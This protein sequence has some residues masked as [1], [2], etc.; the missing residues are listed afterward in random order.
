MRKIFFWLFLLV[1][2]VFVINKF[3]SQSQIISPLADSEST[4]K[5][6]KIFSKKPK[7]IKNIS[8][9][10][11]QIKNLI[12]NQKGTYSVYIYI[13]RTNQSAGVNESV[14]YTG[15]S[16]NKVPILAALYFE[17]QNGKI[18]LSE[19]VTVQ[20]SDIQDYGTGVL[21]NEG[22]GGVYSLKNLAK[23]MME[24][25]DNTAAFILDQK[26]GDNRVQ[27]LV[28][29]WGLSQTDM[30][31]NLTSNKNMADL[32]MKMYQG[33]IVNQPLT[34]EMMDF[35]NDSDFENRLPG[36]L[37]GNI[38]VYHKIGTEIGYIH[39]VGIIDLPENPYYLGVLSSDISDENQTEKTIADISKLVFDFMNK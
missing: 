12:N 22:A 38:E 18:D 24:Q 9:I 35:L 21:R 11:P 13:L 7:D 10:I 2:F 26:I 16:L 17:A 4:F 25:S 27:E 3:R 28:D 34:L 29:S 8:D 19:R 15:A 1:L 20:Q 14:A 36:E 6:T 37:P 31:N 32:F 5:L 30:K 39:D 23:L 33:K